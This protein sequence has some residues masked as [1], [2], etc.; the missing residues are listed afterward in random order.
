MNF[1]NFSVFILFFSIM[2]SSGF[3]QQK[4]TVK[5]ADFK[6]YITNPIVNN[7][8]NQTG[9]FTYNDRD[10]VTTSFTNVRIFVSGRNQSSISATLLNDNPLKLFAGANTD[11]GMG[12]YYSIDGGLNW[13]G[14]D[15]VPGS[16]L[17]SSNPS[18]IYGNN[19]RIH[20][21]YFDN[22]I[23]SD[24]SN[25]FGNSWLGRVIV[26]SSN[27]F[28]MNNST[29]DINASSSYYGRIYSAWSNFDVS[30]PTIYF[31]YSSDGGATYTNSVQ[32]GQPTTSHYE[33]GCN[34]Q[35]GPN[36]EVYCVWA[37]PNSTSNL[38]DHIAFTKSVNGGSGWSA[39]INVLTINGIKGTILNTGI[40]SHSFPSMA[41]DRTG[42]TR[43]GY[44]Y[45]CW[46]QKNLVP[47]GSDA[48]ICFAYSANGG[49]S[50]STP[51][52]VNDDP[53]NNGK[54]QFL[55]RI[56]VDQSNGK[57][58]I[59][60][61]DTRDFIYADSCHTYMAVSA[62]GGNSFF[63]MRVSSASQRPVPL[64]GYSDGYYTD[65]NSVVGINDS[66]F[67]FWTDNRNGPAQVYFSTV[68][69]KP[70]ITHNKLKD[71][72]SL[73]GPYVVNASI[74]IFGTGLASGETKIFWGRGSITDSIVMT[75]TSGN[76]WTAN[77]P[78]N[79]SAVNYN[80]YIKTKD[81][82]GRV[83][84]LPDNAPSSS[85]TFRT[86]ADSEKPQFFFTPFPG[87]Q[88]SQ[89]PDTVLAKVTDNIGI[90]SVWVVWY[91][92]SPSN[93]Y[94]RFKLNLLTDDYY[95]GIFNSTQSQVEPLD[96]IFYRIVA[97]DNSSNHNI[98]STSLN[99]FY[100]WQFYVVYIGN[101]TSVT[102]YPFKTY[103]TD[104]RTDMLYTASELISNGGAISRV[105]GIGF[106]VSNVSPQIMTNFN[107]RIKNTT[108]NSVTGFNSSGWTNVYP[109]N[110]T[111]DGTGWRYIAFQTPFIWDG[112][113]NLLVEICFDNSSFNSNSSVLATP[114][115]NMVWHQSQDLPSGNGCNDLTG[116]SSQPLRPNIA[117]VMNSILSVKENE[118][119]V[120]RDYNL[121]QNYPNPFN[122]VTKINFSIPKKEFVTL[123][124]YDILG[125]EISTLV[126]EIKSPGNFTIDFNG[127]NLSSGVYFYKLTTGDFSD[128]KRMILIK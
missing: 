43:N 46:A 1:K 118:N 58:A 108:Q 20:Y 120:P 64:S 69:L 107:L 89:W 44:I 71:S 90:D 5:P 45:V 24:R 112:T 114:I 38:E 31:S 126:N 25:N 65:Y 13:T 62:D 109:L 17:F 61:Y 11:I 55:P 94:N 51:V 54:L 128:V 82:S 97:Q 57:I 12:Y 70:Y 29:S 22:F 50:W 33:Q 105:I 110:Y 79:G 74:N 49:S 98:D 113:S 122:P 68:I 83:S 15:I 67:L 77:I 88:K 93:G 56:T 53:I 52:K 99:K 3:S 42:G 2:V 127:E 18:C 115:S 4:M 101:G 28:D 21:N 60:F 75:N 40:R 123:K 87:C 102:S 26:P 80:Y 27:T 78:G 92:N 117:F 125:R 19:S 81:V 16:S 111:V 48:D 119:S 41:V 34:L 124:I 35:V 8:Q 36:G 14:N 66:F 23:V 100:I 84:Y 59:L 121:S 7:S 73:T 104:S 91:K 76:N 32:I 95:Q 103:Y 6:P 85:F 116:G 10:I 72:E 86:G 63:N 106:N 30:S 96:S 9:Y 37:T 39:P 47:A